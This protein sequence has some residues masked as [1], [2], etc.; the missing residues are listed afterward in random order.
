MVLLKNRNMNLFENKIIKNGATYIKMV[1]F[2]YMTKTEVY[3]DFIH[4]IQ[5]NRNQKVFFSD[6]F[7]VG[8]VSCI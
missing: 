6:N 8:K 4:L 5:F 3:N 1:L 7:L 2:G